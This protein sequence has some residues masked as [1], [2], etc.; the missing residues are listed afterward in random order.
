M[1]E[2]VANKWRLSGELP[3]IQAVLVEW[4]DVSPTCHRLKLKD[5]GENRG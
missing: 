5:W 1:S 3:E 4:E 2:Q